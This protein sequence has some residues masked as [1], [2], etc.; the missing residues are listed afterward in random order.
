MDTPSTNTRGMYAMTGFM[1][2][3]AGIVL[4]IA[5]TRKYTLANRLNWLPSERGK[6]FQKVYFVV[7][8]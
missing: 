1:A 7:L 3:T 8:T 6:K 5:C 4:R 2:E